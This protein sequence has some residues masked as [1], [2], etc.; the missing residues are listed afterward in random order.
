[1]KKLITLILVSIFCNC[2][3]FAQGEK[4]IIESQ[5]LEYLN[6]LVTKDFQKSTNYMADEFLALFKKEQLIAVMEK[7][8]N[9][10]NVEFQLK[11]PKVISVDETKHIGDKNYAF[12][13]YS[14]LLLMKFKGE[15]IETAEGAKVRN[16][17]IKDALDKSFGNDNVKFDEKT[18]WFEIYS[19]KKVCAISRDEKATWKFIVL[20]PK[21]KALIEKILPKELSAAI[22]N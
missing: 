2:L 20:E 5:F 10:P 12:L 1:M 13:T 22:E 14:N 8:F 21:Q 11:N 16:S 3:T 18:N 7:T 9:D 15:E 19:A 17:L 6:A 4:K